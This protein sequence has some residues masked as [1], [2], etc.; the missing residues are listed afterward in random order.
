MTTMNKIILMGHLGND[1]K[2][3]LCTNGKRVTLFNIA[4]NEF[5]KGADGEKKKKT[6]WHKITTHGR[7]AEVCEKMLKKGS[8]VF[9]IVRKKRLKN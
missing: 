8:L 5:I 4:T 1:P 2:S 9:G 3:I 7:T 6:D